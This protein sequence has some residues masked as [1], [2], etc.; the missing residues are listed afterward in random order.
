MQSYQKLPKTVNLVE[1]SHATEK[2]S[3]NSQIGISLCAVH[4]RPTLDGQNKT[5]AY[6]FISTIKSQKKMQKNSSKWKLVIHLYSGN[7]MENKLMN[8]IIIFISPTA[9]SFP[10]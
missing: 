6:L 8:S 3:S 7:E 9:Y 4:S 10:I 1:D 5:K 2:H